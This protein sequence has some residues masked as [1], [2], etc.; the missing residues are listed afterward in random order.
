MLSFWDVFF[1]FWFCSQYMQILKIASMLLSAA[2][3]IPWY[4]AWNRFSCELLSASFTRKTTIICL[5]VKIIA[6][7]LHVKSFAL[8]SSPCSRHDFS[9]DFFRKSYS[10]MGKETTKT[11]RLGCMNGILLHVSGQFLLPVPKFFLL[12]TWKSSKPRQLNTFHLEQFYLPP[13]RVQWCPVL[14]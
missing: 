9:E 1:V 2:S 6:H 11:K 5:I 8:P 7:S 13:L 10:I 14:N 3:V 12:C 4:F